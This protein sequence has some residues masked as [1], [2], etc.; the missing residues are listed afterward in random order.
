MQKKNYKLNTPTF[1]KIPESYT[2]FYTK[3][4]KIHEKNLL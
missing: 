2:K 3:Q 4:E 1:F